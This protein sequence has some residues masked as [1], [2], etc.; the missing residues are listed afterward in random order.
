MES[1]SSA[2]PPT[3]ANAEP[4]D[5]VVAGAE[6]LNP[7]GSGREY[8]LFGPAIKLFIPFAEVRHAGNAWGSNGVR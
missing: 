4:A 6:R 7:V 8:H 3:S 2:I 1:K 5:G